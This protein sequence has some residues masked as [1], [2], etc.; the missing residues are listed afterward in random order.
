[1]KM[2]KQNSISDECICREIKNSSLQFQLNMVY[3]CIIEANNSTL[4]SGLK[5]ESKN[6]LETVSV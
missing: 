1:M 5:H 3:G 2:L 4:K 6:S